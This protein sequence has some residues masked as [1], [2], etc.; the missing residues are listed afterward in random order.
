M[1]KTVDVKKD[2]QCQ[3]RALALSLYGSE[4]YHATVKEKILRYYL[5]NSNVFGDQKVCYDTVWFK[6]MNRTD[7]W[8]DFGTIYLAHKLFGKA[9]VIVQW[10]VNKLVFQCF[11]TEYDACVFRDLIK[12]EDKCKKIDDIF[13]MYKD[14]HYQLI[15]IKVGPFA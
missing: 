6:E 9:I 12:D 11:G 3:F 1:M 10:E 15:D 5:K 4:E 14:E 13:L 2:G 7:S 8:G